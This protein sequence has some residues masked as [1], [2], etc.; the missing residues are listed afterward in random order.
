MVR[1][2]IATLRSLVPNSLHKVQLN[3]PASRAALSTG[4]LPRAAAS[5]QGKAPQSNG[6]VPELL[7]FGAQQCTC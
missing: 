1:K 5:T 2:R 6:L 4:L 7:V 3:D